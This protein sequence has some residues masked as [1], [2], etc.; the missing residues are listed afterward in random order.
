MGQIKRKEDLSLQ[1]ETSTQQATIIFPLDEGEIDPIESAHKGLNIQIESSY[2]SNLPVEDLLWEA[3]P[4]PVKQHKIESRWW[5]RT[6]KVLRIHRKHPIAMFFTDLMAFGVLSMI[7]LG[8]GNGVEFFSNFLQGV[9]SN[10]IVFGIGV[11]FSIAYILPFIFDSDTDTH[12]PHSG[13]NPFN[14]K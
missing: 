3:N 14:Q 1:E 4:T 2:T 11:V 6:K 13:Y 10:K 9:I 7:I 12:Q 8:P 5:T